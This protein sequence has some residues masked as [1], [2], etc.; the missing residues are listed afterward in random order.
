MLSC[1][2]NSADDPTASAP[3]DAER[4]E[5]EEEE[6]SPARSDVLEEEVDV[7]TVHILW[8]LTILKRNINRMELDVALN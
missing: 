4:E 5:Q 7:Q 3:I 1:D 8:L 2:L 6:N